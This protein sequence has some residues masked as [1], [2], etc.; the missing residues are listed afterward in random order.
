MT[1]PLVLRQRAARDVDDV[2]RQLT[3]AFL[4]VREAVLSGRRVVLVV[5]DRD[6]LGQGA[7]EDAAVANGLLGLMRAVAVEG[8][9]PGWHVCAVAHTDP[10]PVSA[11]V[12]AFATSGAGPSGQLLR[13]STV[14]LGRVVP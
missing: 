3:Q 12:M 1:E 5:Q 9:R 7:A 14:H 11:A 6:L 2:G 8:T 13:T 4:A 10:E